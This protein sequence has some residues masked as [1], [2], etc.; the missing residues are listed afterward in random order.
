MEC[1]GSEYPVNYHK[2]YVCIC[3]ALMILGLSFSFSSTLLDRGAK[4]SMD[5]MAHVMTAP[6]QHSTRRLLLWIMHDSCKLM[7]IWNEWTHCRA[8]K[9]LKIDMS[10]PWRRHYKRVEEANERRPSA[11][12]Q[13]LDQPSS[14]LCTAHNGHIKKKNT[15]DSWR[16][17][18][19]NWLRAQAAQVMGA[20][21]S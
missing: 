5:D 20:T 10:R 19:Q 13:V 4:V 1:L 3:M 9:H 2:M 21:H 18:K 6:S 17:S 15:S 11:N 14:P 7:H 12:Q 8:H 16:T